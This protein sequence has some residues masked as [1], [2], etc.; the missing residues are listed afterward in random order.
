[1]KERIHV[2]ADEIDEEAQAKQTKNNRRHTGQ[3][4]DGAADYPGNRR[5]GSRVFA[6]VNGGD[7]S[8]GNDEDGHEEDARG[9]ADDHWQHTRG[10]YVEH[11][12]LSARGEESQ[13]KTMRSQ[14]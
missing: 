6:E 12:L 10:I 3:V 7:N 8:D 13:G 5:S 11:V 1:M 14:H 9:G 4:I 2:F